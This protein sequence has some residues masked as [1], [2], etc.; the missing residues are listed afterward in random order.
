MYCKILHFYLKRMK[1]DTSTRSFKNSL[2]MDL[3]Q[4]GALHASPARNLLPQGKSKPGTKRTTLLPH[5][6][7]HT[8]WRLVKFALN[9]REAATSGQYC[10]LTN[11]G[12][13]S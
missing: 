10:K 11:S 4:C 2:D 1:V 5:T 13:N 3:N 8:N 9:M 6:R 7:H 12:V